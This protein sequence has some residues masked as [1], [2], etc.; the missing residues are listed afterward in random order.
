MGAK[1]DEDK[2]SESDKFIN[3]KVPAFL[4]KAEELLKKSGGKYFVGN[5]VIIMTKKYN[6]EICTQTS[7]QLT[8]FKL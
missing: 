7:L 4:E 1:T 2:K 5:K 8:H 3:E 6:S